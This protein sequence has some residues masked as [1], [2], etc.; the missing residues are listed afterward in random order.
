L[1]HKSSFS[2]CGEVHFSQKEKALEK[3]MKRIIR[4]EGIEAKRKLITYQ[5]LMRRTYIQ[6]KGREN[7]QRHLQNYVRAYK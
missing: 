4:M 1:N 6:I 2:V 7:M 3:R 5:D